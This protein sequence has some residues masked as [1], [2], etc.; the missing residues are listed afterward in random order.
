MNF[1]IIGEMNLD[2]LLTEYVANCIE[3]LLC[4]GGVVS[5]VCFVCFSGNLLVFLHK[6][7]IL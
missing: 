4:N 5:Y 2:A 7:I 3:E 6:C 1:K